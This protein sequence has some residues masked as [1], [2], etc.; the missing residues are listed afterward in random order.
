MGY[1]VEFRAHLR[2]AS[3]VCLRGVVDADDPRFAFE[4]AER[5]ASVIKG[6]DGFI[7]WGDEGE[8]IA[9]QK[10]TVPPVED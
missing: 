1:E 5:L 8:P 6:A 9:M 10:L 2:D 4:Q 7:L 3:S